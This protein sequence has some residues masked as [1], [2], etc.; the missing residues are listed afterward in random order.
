MEGK[1]TGED[2]ICPVCTKTIPVKILVKATEADVTYR[3]RKGN[4][5]HLSV[6]MTAEVVETVIE[7][8]CTPRVER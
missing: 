5:A 4:E 7:H 3:G 2:L 1:W 8:R 6:N